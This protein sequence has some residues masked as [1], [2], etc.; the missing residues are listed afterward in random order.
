MSNQEEGNENMK[1]ILI[2]IASLALA[3]TA[4]GQ[5]VKGHTNA[6]ATA[7]APHAS[8]VHA[9][10]S[11]NRRAA[12]SNM[13][14]RGN[15]TTSTRF[16]QRANVSAQTRSSV[17]ANRN[18]MRTATARTRIHARN[19]AMVNSRRGRNVGMVQGVRTR[20]NANVRNRTNAY[21]MVNVNDRSRF[22]NVRRITSNGRTFDRAVFRD[23]NDWR[24][25]LGFHDRAFFVNRFSEVVF[26]NGC[27]FFLDDGIFWPAFITGEGCVPAPNVVFIAVP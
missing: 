1:G 5:E 25:R 2:C 4:Q 18:R 3:L 22:T 27:S 20:G 15:V 26:I 17:A 8:N 7:K 23:R 19:N 12:T 9:A 6:S 16:H 10:T 21:A 24:L 11:A 13:R 14:S